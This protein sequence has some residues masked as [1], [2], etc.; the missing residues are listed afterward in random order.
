MW[1]TQ[2][3]TEEKKRGNTLLKRERGTTKINNHEERRGTKSRVGKTL[4]RTVSPRITGVEQKKKLRQG[5][6][7]R[8]KGHEGRTSS[9]KK[10]YDRKKK[11]KTVS[12]KKPTPQKGK[13]RPVPGRATLM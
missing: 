9:S 3:K 4:C 5:K 7:P 11:K 8:L 10:K 1:H 2:K 13:N 6:G 12:P